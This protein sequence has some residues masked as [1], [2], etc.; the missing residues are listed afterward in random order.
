ML[1]AYLALLWLDLVCAYT[2]RCQDQALQK[3]DLYYPC[4]TTPLFGRIKVCS[5]PC[6]LQGLQDDLQDYSDREYP[7]LSGSLT[8]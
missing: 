7:F 2:D 8:Y 4:A 6:S 5:F 1:A 3:E